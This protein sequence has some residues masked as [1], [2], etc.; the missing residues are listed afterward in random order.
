MT[1]MRIRYRM[2][3]IQSNGFVAVN[4]TDPNE[5]IACNITYAL[6]VR[7]KQI[8]VYAGVCFYRK[9]ITLKV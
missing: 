6:S 4:G 5:L 7:E 8:A 1:G 2:L 9:N 3:K